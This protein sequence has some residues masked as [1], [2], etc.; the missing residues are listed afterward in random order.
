M[1]YKK[2]EETNPRQKDQLNILRKYLTP[3]PF[4]RVSAIIKLWNVGTFDPAFHFFN[5]SSNRPGK[6]FGNLTQ[7]FSTSWKLT[8]S[9][10]PNC[11]AQFPIWFDNAFKT[12]SPGVSWSLKS[13]IS[14]RKIDCYLIQKDKY[15]LVCFPVLL[16]TTGISWAFKTI[17]SV[18][19][20]VSLNY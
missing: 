4:T 13:A 7:L 11:S 15:V 2:T 10:I 18:V 17:L 20:Y 6:S 5:M 3:P 14:D 1:F 16:N 9:S 19:E 8:P 12:S